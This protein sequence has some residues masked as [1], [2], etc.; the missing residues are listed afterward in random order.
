MTEPKAKAPTLTD[1]YVSR[2]QSIAGAARAM[3]IPDTTLA[4]A[5]KKGSAQTA[6]VSTLLQHAAT[7]EERQAVYH[8]FRLVTGGAE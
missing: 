3:G 2:H 1:I 8:H 6:L 5:M 4:R 7:A